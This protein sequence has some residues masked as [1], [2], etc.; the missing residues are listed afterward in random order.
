MAR[1]RVLL[2][3]GVLLVS[4]GCDQATKRLAIDRLDGAP[5]ISL[6]GD[7]V[8]FE[9][10]ANPGGFLSLGSG[11]PSELRRL[12]FLVLAP[13]CVLLVCA[14]ALRSRS[15]SAAA[16]A[17]LGLVAGGGLGNWLDRLQAGAVT[18]F[19]SLGVGGLWTGIFNL[20]DVAVVAGVVWLACA[21]SDGPSQRSPSERPE[22]E[23]PER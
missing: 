15:V 1:G 23:G 12:V 20:A 11:L 7:A 18:D 22:A 5:P 14:L 4:A 16:M 8:R 10:T 19:V 9:L 6:A 21:R 13:A 2:F 17:G 3:V